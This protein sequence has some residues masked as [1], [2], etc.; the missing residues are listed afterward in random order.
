M[1]LD[2]MRSE[3]S[4]GR[5]IYLLR[6]GLPI[7][8]DSEHFHS[9]VLETTAKTLINEIIIRGTVHNIPE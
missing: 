3:T 8:P 6:L 5:D 4:E 7:E 9:G 1:A 2:G